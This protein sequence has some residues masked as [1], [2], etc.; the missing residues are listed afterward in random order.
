MTLTPFQKKLCNVL[1]NGLP[2][3]AKPFTQIADKLGSDEATVLAETKIL[4]ARGIIRRVSATVNYKVFGKTSTLVT[5]H[6]VQR[7][8]DSV[9]AAVNKL[10]GVSHNY[11]RDHF[12]NLWFTLQGDSNN[13]IESIIAKLSSDTGAEFHSLPAVQTF[14]LDVRFDAESDGKSL[15]P[16]EEGISIPKC[17]KAFLNKEEKNIVTK[18]QQNLEIAAE[19]FSSARTS[20]QAI[21]N[22]INKGAIRRIAAV[23]D[24][25]NLGF[26]ANAMFACTVE[27]ARIAE[28][29]GRLAELNNVS[30]CY[31]RQ[32][33][34]G[35]P[36]NLFGM[37]HGRDMEQI[38]GVAASFVSLEEIKEFVL[39]KTLKEFKKKPVSV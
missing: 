24:Y 4:I 34:I 22:L 27:G 9:V 10:E 7:Q 20:V 28:L 26:T 12:Y 32:T 5:A 1:Q 2:I 17:T 6:I 21:Q 33:F 29:G 35:W 39:L 3:T 14:K 25:R 36:Y 30:H 37:M 11:L 18:L 19:P 16:F 15:L 13:Q 38:A 8:L 31:R 23:V